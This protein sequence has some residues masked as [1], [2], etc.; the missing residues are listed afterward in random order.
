MRVKY[1]FF[2]SNVRS[3]TSLFDEAAAFASTFSPERLIGISH[4][5]GGTGGGIGVV[6]VWY[7]EDEA[8]VPNLQWK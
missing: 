4:S 5:H 7:W 8:S 3:W 6:T 2:E 1:K